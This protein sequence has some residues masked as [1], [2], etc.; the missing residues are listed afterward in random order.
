MTSFLSTPVS[1]KKQR[2][3][4]GPSSLI[5][6]IP[7]EEGDHAFPKKFG[8]LQGCLAFGSTWRPPQN[9]ASSST[10][11]LSLL[12]KKYGVYPSNNKNRPI[13]NNT[14]VIKC[15]VP[16]D[17]KRFS[18]NIAAP[19]HDNFC[20]ILFHFNPRQYEHGGKVVLN[21]K[22]NGVWGRAIDIPLSE[23]PVVFGR[24]CVFTVQMDAM[25]FNVFV[26]GKR[27]AHFH[28]RQQLKS[29]W[30]FL[31]LQCPSTDDYGNREDWKVEQVWWGDG[32]PIV[33]HR[34]HQ[35][36]ISPSEVIPGVPQG[37]SLHPR[38]LFIRRLTKLSTDSDLEKRRAMLE[39]AFSRYGGRLGVTTWVPKNRSYA[40]VEAE[41][42]EKA[43]LAI[44]EMGSSFCI[45]RARR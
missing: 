38:K 24:Q 27:G 7:Q 6:L 30:E 10:G 15:S 17:A 5:D 2:I 45:S 8:L 22:C 41:T 25:G 44:L 18:F 37:D 12:L 3:D 43:D 35:S 11:A 40:F 31:V 16:A 28:H 39:R 34:A 1:R 26:D 13:V 42:Q 19:T 33:A 21:D 29:S 36:T 14:L 32:A 23:F 20:N 9:A 4:R